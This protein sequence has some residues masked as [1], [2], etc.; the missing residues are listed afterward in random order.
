MPR[1]TSNQTKTS[2]P[3]IN[4]SEDPTKYSNWHLTIN[5]NKYPLIPEQITEFKEELSGVLKELYAQKHVPLLFTF[6]IPGHMWG[7]EY[8]KSV[9]IKYAVEVGH[10]PGGGRIHS[11]SIIKVV[12]NSSIK[13]DLQYI[14]KF[15]KE[16]YGYPVYVHYNMVKT[17]QALEDYLEKDQEEIIE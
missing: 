8:V 14:R 10:S 2:K 13:L 4:K 1:V 12:H 15:L 7:D 6:D 3:K 11:H 9:D 16:K 5:P 17:D